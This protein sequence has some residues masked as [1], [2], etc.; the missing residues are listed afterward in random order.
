MDGGIEGCVLLV[1]EGIQVAA[2]LLKAVD[3]LQGIAPASTLEGDVLAEM[4]QSLLAGLFVACTGSNLI[5]AVDDRRS[6]LQMDDPKAILQ[7]GSIVFHCAAKVRKG[8]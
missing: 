1:C 6:R 2:H 8:S 4:R 3:D 5:T 7:N